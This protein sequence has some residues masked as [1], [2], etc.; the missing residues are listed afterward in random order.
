MLGVKIEDL[1]VT[2]NSQAIMTPAEKFQRR[3]LFQ[4]GAYC[5]SAQRNSIKPASK[6]RQQSAAGQPP[7]YHNTPLLGG[8]GFKGTIF[9]AVDTRE[10][11]VSIGPILLNGSHSRRGLVPETLEHGGVTVVNKG[12]RRK[13][14]LVAVEI[15]AR[16]SAQPAYERSVK[17]KLPDL[18]KGGIMREV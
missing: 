12:S 18:I 5:M 10:K 6:K 3:L 14:R 4:F 8:K 17:K 15:R 11:T 16:P 13:Q 9:Y 7:V 1:K 2:W